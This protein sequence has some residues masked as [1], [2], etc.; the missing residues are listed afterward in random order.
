MRHISMQQKYINT[1]K[2]GRTRIVDKH[3]SK[4]GLII[5]M[6]TN[7]DSTGEV[8]RS[9]IIKRTIWSV[10]MISLFILSIMLS[11]IYI[12]G[13]VYLIKALSIREILSILNDG[14]KIKSKR[15]KGLN[16]YFMIIADL[17]LIG[18]TIGNL[19][20]RFM[21]DVIKVHSLF[22]IFSLYVAGLIVF[23]VNLRRKELRDQFA[24][25]ALTQFVI[26]IL[27]VTTKFCI[28]NIS[29]GLLWFVLPVIL[30]VSNDIFAFIFGKIFGKTKLIRLSPNKTWEG[31]IG[32]M[33]ATVFIGI[34]FIYFRLKWGFFPDKYDQVLNMKRCLHLF[35][36]S[37]CLDNLYIHAMA[38]IL[39]ASL[40]A[41]FG[42]F[43]ASGLKRAFRVKD[44]GEAIPGH[45]GFTDRMDCQFLMGVF[46]YVYHY[47]FIREK[48]VT[49]SMLFSAILKNLNKREIGELVEMLCNAAESS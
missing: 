47:T 48:V 1:S 45:G 35:N 24:Y 20:N 39:F 19:Y 2:K 26:Y 5:R 18:T 34:L 28:I 41:P 17:Y 10:V 32:G 3:T 22:Y 49:K 40:I 6:S 43:F 16:W 37:M 21:P 33:F 11:K 23:I 31:F 12:I 14:M 7:I 4:E 13:I 9:K 46:S 27:G 30:V 25:F 29:N 42:G 44:F 15:M 8:A 36:Y 38:Y